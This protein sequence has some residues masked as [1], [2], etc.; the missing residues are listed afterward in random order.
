[1]KDADNLQSGLFSAATTYCWDVLDPISQKGIL[2]SIRI[3]CQEA[4]VRQEDSVEELSRLAV[5]AAASAAPSS[6]TRSPAEAINLLRLLTL[7]SKLLSAEAAAQFE[8]ELSSLPKITRASS[9]C[10]AFW[11]EIIPTSNRKL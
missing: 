7:E 8:V 2:E 5:K 6:E 4:V 1:M 9:C 11:D 10:H 3:G